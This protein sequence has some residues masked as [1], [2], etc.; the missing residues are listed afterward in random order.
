MRISEAPSF[1]RKRAAIYN[2]VDDS[3]TN[4]SKRQKKFVSPVARTGI[5]KQLPSNASIGIPK[6]GSCAASVMCNQYNVTRTAANKSNP[7]DIA[8]GVITL[9]EDDGDGEGKV[10]ND[11]NR[12]QAVCEK[13][14]LSGSG[15]FAAKKKARLGVGL[16]KPRFRP[17][18]PAQSL[19]GPSP[20]QTD[21]PGCPSTS[22]KSSSIA[23]IVPQ[24]CQIPRKTE[25]QSPTS[26]YCVMYCTRK[27][28]AKHKGPWSDGVLVCRGRSCTLQDTEGKVVTK[29]NGHRGGDKS[30][31][32][33]FPIGKF[34]VEILT[35]STEEAFLSGKIFTGTLDLE[36]DITINLAPKSRFKSFK[37]PILKH[38]RDGTVLPST[39]PSTHSGPTN[40]H[41]SLNDPQKTT[42][43]Q[44]IVTEDSL[45]LNTKEVQRGA[46]P[47]IVDPYLSTKLR[48]HQREGVQFMYECVMGLKNS[49]FTGCLLA[50]AMG[51]GKT[52]Q[53]IALIWTLLHQGPKGRPAVRRVLVICPSS[54]VEN[55][56]KEVRKWLGSERLNALIIHSGTPAKDVKQSISKFQIGKLAPVLVTSYELLRKH[57]EDLRSAKAEL[58]V[59]DEA[60][61][62]KN[63]AGNKTIDALLALKCSMKVLLTGTPVQNDLMEFYAMLDFANKDLLGP[64]SAFKRLYADPIQK[65][66]DRN[67]SDE[68]KKLGRTRSTELQYR[69]RSFIL[70]RSADVNLMYL[71]VKTELI[72]FC[73]LQAPQ[74]SLYLDFLKSK[75][76]ETL[77]LPTSHSAVILSAIGTLRKLCNHP[78]LVQAELKKQNNQRSCNENEID[79]CQSDDWGQS[80]KLDCL[81]KMI[82]A[83][84]AD[85][86]FGPRD[87]IVVV[88]NFTQTLDIIQSLCE[89][90]KWKWLR[91]D[92][93]TEV[94]ERQSKVDRF[95]SD[96]SE[97]RIFLLSSKAG[98]TGLNLIGA[99]RLVLFDPDWNPAT[100][101]QAM[102]RVWR[103]GQR[104][105]VLIYRLLSTGSLEEKIYQRQIMKQEIAAAV[106]EQVEGQLGHAGRHFSREELR[107]L[108]TLRLDTRCDTYDLLTKSS[109]RRTER[110]RDYSDEL[111]DHALESAIKT[112][113]VTFVHKVAGKLDKKIP[114]CSSSGLNTTSE[115]SE[116]STELDICENES[117][118]LSTECPPISPE[119]CQEPL[120]FNGSFLANRD[121]SDLQQP[122]NG[123][124]SVVS[125]KTCSPSVSTEFEDDEDFSNH[126]AGVSER[127]TDIEELNYNTELNIN[128]Q[129]NSPM[130][131][132]SV[133]INSHG[134]DPPMG[135]IESDI[136]VESVGREWEKCRLGSCKGENEMISEAMHQDIRDETA[137]TR[138]IEASTSA[139][140][141]SEGGCSC[142]LG[143]EGHKLLSYMLETIGPVGSDVDDLEALDMPFLSSM[144]LELELERAQFTPQKLWE[145]F[146]LFALGFIVGAK[147]EQIYYSCCTLGLILEKCNGDKTSSVQ[148][149][150]GDSAIE[151]SHLLSV[152]EDVEQL[153]STTNGRYLIEVTRRCKSLEHN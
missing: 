34:E 141:Q 28:N 58:L 112:G 57:N 10:S 77:F 40:L 36:A 4:L 106:G 117:S 132:L 137:S 150:H 85:T 134:R 90:E 69:T 63:C 92:G 78:K 56:G 84:H 31:G 7:G 44:R 146:K 101:A 107:E 111:Q 110:W 130:R 67:A 145:G 11:Q 75:T 62:L 138:L 49:K 24:S 18:A 126:P 16:M 119:S 122:E 53:V 114:L 74:I 15:H 39:T 91:L 32:A 102:A 79:S 151:L 48:Q 142:L 99:N 55:W 2:E 60:H 100:D 105:P 83:L 20:I 59:C 118:L 89:Q 123:N 30:E 21:S 103:D 88:S 116:E 47:V 38:S 13:Q 19:S 136:E 17:P 52:L 143:D 98:G 94:S 1:I 43:G 115:L 22:S 95:N 54:L 127:P 148:R 26:Y 23:S 71:P 86:H 29:D 70:Q 25:E 139:I 35:K 87:K 68:E 96:Y 72:V 5:L 42:S 125:D 37:R 121:L 3:S 65:S 153:S 64:L 41:R 27:P 149:R 14:V 152:Y 80:G 6:G 131:S 76:V 109:A 135:D 9:E 133:D 97:E 144:E 50:D 46:S 108:F 45:I 33:M 93:T 120:L 140:C 73:K 113:T 147:Q 82:S 124:R 12:I 61:R 104:K 129:A 8:T 66:R 81:H 51:L 128:H